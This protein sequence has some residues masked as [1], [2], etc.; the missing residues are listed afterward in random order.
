MSRLRC[1]A[2]SHRETIAGAAI[3]AA[4]A[5]PDFS[6]T[7][8]L[9]PLRS[10]FN[11]SLPAPKSLILTISHNEPKLHLE[12]KL[13]SKE[14]E[15]DLSFDLTTDGAEAKA[16]GSGDDCV[17]SAKWGDLDGTRLVL[18]I[19]QP[20]SNGTVVTNRVMKLGRN[21]NMITTVLHV[22][23]AKGTLKADEFF[24]REK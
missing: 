17:A 23:G 7:W 21:K 20:G 19:K 13:E 2:R 8:K 9:D 6:G 4:D 5:K 3:A 18:T 22:T 15:R 11:E 16:A 24:E 12:L 14:G 10:R 1:R